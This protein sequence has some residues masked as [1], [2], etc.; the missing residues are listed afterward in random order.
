MLSTDSWWRIVIA[1]VDR[2]QTDDLMGVETKE[3]FLIKPRC[4]EDQV[5]KPIGAYSS[6]LFTCSSGSVDT[7]HR[8]T[9]CSAD[10]GWVT[11]TAS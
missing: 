1:I 7:I 3:S 4:M 5:R 8:L 10:K 9:G 6:I 2:F 11:F